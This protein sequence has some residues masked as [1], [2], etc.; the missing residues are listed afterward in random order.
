MPVLHSFLRWST[1]EQSL[2]TSETRQVERLRD[3]AIQEGYDYSGSYRSPGIGAYR[4]KQRRIGGL[5][6]FLDDLKARNIPQGDVLGVENFDRLSR[7]PTIDALDLFRE[8]IRSGVGLVVNRVLFT[9]SILR[10]QSG[11]WH[12]VIAEFNRANEESNRKGSAV[13]AANDVNRRAAAEKKR[14]LHGRN[15]PRWLLPIRTGPKDPPDWYDGPGDQG[16]AYHII[17]ERLEVLY[18]IIRLALEGFGIRKI[19]AILNADDNKVPTWEWRTKNRPE[20]DVWQS[21]YIGKILNSEALV[22]RIQPYKTD[23]KGDLQPQGDPI[24]GHYP[25]IITDAEFDRLQA[26]LARRRVYSGGRNT[27]RLPNLVSGLCFCSVCKGRVRYKLQPTRKNGKTFVKEYLVCV[28]AKEGGCTNREGFPYRVLEATL[29]DYPRHKMVADLR[30]EERRLEAALTEARREQSLRQHDADDDFLMLF[31]E[32][33]MRLNDPDPEV[34][35]AARRVLYDQYHQR[36]E[37]IWLDP[38]RRLRILLNPTAAGQ[39]EIGLFSARYSRSIRGER[40]LRI[41]RENATE[42]M[43]LDELEL[44]RIERIERFQRPF[45]N[46]SPETSG[47]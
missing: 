40:T 35:A 14:A 27:G 22:G 29:I 30:A 8:I 11:L 9:E 17:L 33:K 1:P 18:R 43:P 28:N 5:K 46:Y 4:G 45:E 38:G 21:S 10:K 39:F 23:E 12:V 34:A 19:A 31:Y 47:V 16:T 26:A 20:T 25:R 36:I 13:S 3:W 42:S 41:I 2:G 37:R 32:A 7:E 44:E 24:E 15:C 6:D